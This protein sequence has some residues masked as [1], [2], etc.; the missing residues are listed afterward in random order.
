MGWVPLPE[1]RSRLF[2]RACSSK[3]P[4]QRSSLSLILMPCALCAAL[5]MVEQELPVVPD[6]SIAHNAQI[7]LDA[8]QSVGLMEWSIALALA[9]ENTLVLSGECLRKDTMPYALTATSSR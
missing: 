4:A 8:C 2:L 9:L 7:L 3:L 5:E 1:I 6:M